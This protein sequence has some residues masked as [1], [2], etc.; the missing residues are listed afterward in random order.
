MPRVLYADPEYIIHKKCRANPNVTI[1]NLLLLL[2]E[3]KKKS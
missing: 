1:V 3:K 2:T